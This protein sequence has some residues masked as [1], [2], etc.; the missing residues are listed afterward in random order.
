MAIFY[1]SRLRQKS[2]AK[3]LGVLGCWSAG[4]LG[5][6]I[7]AGR[8]DM[9]IRPLRFFQEARSKLRRYIY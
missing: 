6:L 5:L 2:Q 4:V 7:K 9:S 3:R 1:G 8:A